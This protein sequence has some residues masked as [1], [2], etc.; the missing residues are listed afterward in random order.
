MD[1]IKDN[2]EIFVSACRNGQ[3]EEAKQ[4]HLT[5]EIKSDTYDNAFY[6]SC[7]SGNIEIAKW[8]YSLNKGII[9]NY[10]DDAFITCCMN[11]HI[12]IAKWLYSLGNPNIHALNDL[13][14]IRSCEFGH[15][16]IAK[17]LYSLK[18]VNVHVLNDL[19][20]VRSCQ[21][22]HKEIAE[23]LYSLGNINEQTYTKYMPLLS[24]PTR[25]RGSLLDLLNWSA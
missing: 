7:E 22:N 18:G 21:N 20:F 4:M 14:F 16:E 11:G 5:G 25:A 15:I 1:N 23:W 8:L 17:W 2:Y 6:W 12:E 3:F 19:P 9:Y 24:K 13:A 10:N